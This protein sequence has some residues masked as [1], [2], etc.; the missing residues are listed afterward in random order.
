MAASI[1]LSQRLAMARANG[2]AGG[3]SSNPNGIPT[4]VTCGRYQLGDLLGKG[5][6]GRVFRGLNLRTGEVV[7]VKQMD[8]KAISSE[9]YED[10]KRELR[11]LETLDHPN[12]VKF[13][14][15][16]EKEEHL[17]FVLE[18]IEGGSLH[19]AIKKF[20]CF[21]A[22]LIVVYMTQVLRGLHYLHQQGII[23]RD[24]KGANILL[25]KE[26]ICKLA[27]F[28]SCAYTAL[29]RSAS[30]AGTPFWM[31][32]EFIEGTESGPCSDIWSVGCTI[33]ELI[34]GA[35][36][37]WESGPQVALF[38][39]VQNP[40]PPYPAELPEDLTDFLDNCF[41]RDVK[42]R[43][44]AEQLQMHPWI[45]SLWGGRVASPAPP[46]RATPQP[47]HKERPHSLTFNL[48]K[49]DKRS[50]KP[51]NLSKSATVA[52]PKV[53]K[54]KPATDESKKEKEKEKEKE[55][56]K[57]KEKEK[58]KTDSGS[59]KD[60]NDGSHSSE[61]KLS[62]WRMKEAE[63]EKEKKRQKEEKR[64]TRLSMSAGSKPSEPVNKV[65]ENK[66]AMEYHYQMLLM[67]NAKD[68]FTPSSS[69][70]ARPHSMASLETTLAPAATPGHS[71]GISPE[72]SSD[73]KESKGEEQLST[74]P[75]APLPSE[76]PT[77]SIS[78]AL[79]TTLPVKRHSVQLPSGDAAGST[80]ISR[81]QESS[82]EVEKVTASLEEKRKDMILKLSN[83]KH[84]LQEK[85]AELL[86]EA[87]TWV[88]QLSQELSCLTP[89]EKV[90]LPGMRCQAP[91]KK[92]KEITWKDA[93]ISSVDF[94]AS[95]MPVYRVIYIRTGKEAS[96]SWDSIRPAGFTPSLRV[97]SSSDP[98]SSS[99]RLE[100]WT[101][102]EPPSPSSSSTSD[103]ETPEETNKSFRH[104]T[105]SPDIKKGKK[106]HHSAVK[107]TNS[108]K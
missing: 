22:R 2:G 45:A 74:T 75:P 96:L 23:H 77:I 37:Y 53:E 33:L 104:T 26:G 41:I 88:A 71:T 35:P 90:W 99:G 14:E 28:G 19:D 16:F 25:S 107:R 42:Q 10:I 70:E 73:A 87:K 56:E 15:S 80:E 46:R 91:L 17:Y 89:E 83:A 100:D 65:E 102:P 68:S 44:N 76:T 43:P 31:A 79:E 93:V 1:P 98:D 8:K 38:K 4:P 54:A 94:H 20:G 49:K 21:P 7:A 95:S 92:D 39:M 84:E 52:S 47:Q 6:I 12:T 101:V 34:T 108:A 40:K 60:D 55:R 3:A 24:I 85:R 62:W 81:L 66:R 103:G 67:A 57:E 5:V 27:D 63:A 11:L 64:N 105:S 50:E 72:T 97:S 32:P 78:A 29:N 59:D 9:N 48:F 69:P 30:L 51:S 86:T 13:I 61:S 58:S 82:E 18:Y 36:P 106:L